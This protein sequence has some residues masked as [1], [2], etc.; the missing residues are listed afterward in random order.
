MNTTYQVSNDTY[1]SK[2]MF[3]GWF[4]QNLEGKKL[5]LAD[6]PA[7]GLLFALESCPVVSKEAF[8]EAIME[9]EKKRTT[10][11]LLDRREIAEASI[12]QMEAEMEALLARIARRKAEVFELEWKK[13]VIDLLRTK[14]FG[15]AVVPPEKFYFINDINVK[16]CEGRLAYVVEGGPMRLDSTYVDI[17]EYVDKIFKVYC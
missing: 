10:K 1:L 16:Y 6:I 15:E 11:D 3:L 13:A 4:F 5:Y 14:A 7:S 9:T 8:R 17:S 12:G 2:C